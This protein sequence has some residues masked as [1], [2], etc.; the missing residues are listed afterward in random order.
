MSSILLNRGF[1]HR[2]AND[3]TSGKTQPLTEFLHYLKLVRYNQLSESKGNFFLLSLD[4]KTDEYIRE[5]LFAASHENSNPLNPKIAKIQIDESAKKVASEISANQ[6][7]FL[8]CFSKID[9]E[10][11]ILEK[12][13]EK[14]A[15]VASSEPERT[16]R[17]ESKLDEFFTEMVRFFSVLKPGFFR[18]L[19]LEREKVFKEIMESFSQ[20]HGSNFLNKVTN[21]K[22]FLRSYKF[23]AAQ[24][25]LEISS[26]ANKID[27]ITRD[28]LSQLGVTVQKLDLHPFDVPLKN[29]VGFSSVQYDEVRVALYHELKKEVQILKGFLDSFEGKKATGKETRQIQEATSMFREKIM[30]IL[31]KTEY[32]GISFF[33]D[34]IIKR[35]KETENIRTVDNLGDFIE[36]II[37][38]L[39]FLGTVPERTGSKKPRE[40]L[41]ILKDEFELRK[42]EFEDNNPGAT[43]DLS[44]ADFANYVSLKKEP[45]TIVGLLNRVA[46]EI[47]TSKTNSNAEGK[48]YEALS[49]FSQNFNNVLP[50]FLDNLE[51]MMATLKD[52]SDSFRFIAEMLI[53]ADAISGR[54]GDTEEVLKFSS[55]NPKDPALEFENSPF[56]R[57]IKAD[58]DVQK[59]VNN[60]LTTVAL[61]RAALFRS[62]I[63]SLIPRNYSEWKNPFVNLPRL[64]D[65]SLIRYKV[66]EF[67]PYSAIQKLNQLN[68]T[69][70]ES[71][72]VEFL[73]AEIDTTIPGEYIYR[74]GFPRSGK[75]SNNSAFFSENQNIFTF[76][77]TSLG[78]HGK[79]LITETISNEI[80]LHKRN[81]SAPDLFIVT[82][83]KFV[84]FLKSNKYFI[85]TD[86]K[87][88]RIN[89][90][91]KIISIG[92]TRYNRSANSIPPIEG[93]NLKKTL[94]ILLDHSYD[95]RHRRRG[96]TYCI[97]Y[98]NRECKN[99]VAFDNERV[100]RLTE[101]SDLDDYTREALLYVANVTK[102]NTQPIVKTFTR[103]E[104]SLHSKEFYLTVSVVKPDSIFYEPPRNLLPD[105]LARNVPFDVRVVSTNVLPYLPIIGLYHKQI[106]LSQKVE[107]ATAKV[108][109]RDPV[110]MKYFA[111]RNENNF[112]SRNVLDSVEVHD[113]KDPK[114]Q[115]MHN[116][117][118]VLVYSSPLQMAIDI[119]SADGKDDVLSIFN[120]ISRKNLHI[121]WKKY[122]IPLTPELRYNIVRYFNNPYLTS[123][124]EEE[125][126]QKFGSPKI[127]SDSS[128]YTRIMKAICATMYNKLCSHYFKKNGYIDFTHVMNQITYE[129][130]P[131]VRK[132]LESVRNMPVFSQFKLKTETNLIID[133]LN[134]E[135]SNISFPIGNLVNGSIVISLPSIKY[136]SDLIDFGDDNTRTIKT[137]SVANPG[138]TFVIDPDNLVIANFNPYSFRKMKR[139]QGIAKLIDGKYKMQINNQSEQSTYLTTIEP[140]AND[141]T[142]ERLKRLLDCNDRK[143]VENKE[144]ME[145][146]KASQTKKEITTL[147]LLL[148]HSFWFMKLDSNTKFRRNLQISGE[149]TEL[150]C[151]MLAFINKRKTLPTKIE[152]FENEEPLYVSSI[153]REEHKKIFFKRFFMLVTGAEITEESSMDLDRELQQF[154]IT[155]GLVKQK[156]PDRFNYLTDIGLHVTEKDSEIIVSDDFFESNEVIPKII[157]ESRPIKMNIA[158][159]TDR[160][161]NGD[162]PS[163]DMSLLSNIDIITG[164]NIVPGMIKLLKNEKITQSSVGFFLHEKLL[165]PPQR[166]EDRERLAFFFKS[167]NINTSNIHNKL[168]EREKQNRV[169]PA[170]R[171]GTIQFNN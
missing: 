116:T 170:L 67:P 102:V 127:A 162:V 74:V 106:T 92:L 40:L 159:Y 77:D 165:P 32:R 9:K 35:S 167:M 160:D 72:N 93:K 54:F 15:A 11:G 82:Q 156:A 62:K 14:G 150:F 123:L 138:I 142:L 126:S 57:N 18:S 63:D 108:P 95:Y 169:S 13:P 59:I 110:W 124:M 151:Q 132:T 33:G 120:K 137:L 1:L 149:D 112:S 29:W 16:C 85:E 140:I 19:G 28:L 96:K 125:E 101:D 56:F 164:K 153:A 161:I 81:A 25:I 65:K 171:S 36:G 168:I 46:A 87:K 105:D 99:F 80:T 17:L 60:E 130:F 117:G 45:S 51:N 155:E 39:S 128:S 118:A 43:A 5:N 121:S 111:N 66:P 113:A 64:D 97:T 68:E 139:I 131:F 48:T 122:K 20:Y 94:E 21:Y 47:K 136:Y 100:Y 90:K 84:S 24:M 133:E 61:E 146:K 141:V 49:K 38:L 27:E 98:E 8:E 42:K 52:V 4:D 58:S 119:V 143:I 30:K 157:F 2:A 10:L 114:K 34:L 163:L 88:N 26:I 134:R 23:F 70:V 83:F 12:K 76:V 31:G 158:N 41:D 109:A 73:K 91:S 7:K 147:D 71:E 145:A 22:S 79:I 115:L 3:F 154:N 86:I 75:F 6:M 78:S 104:D 144:E 44:N 37:P 89:E 107:N 148:N 55:E 69:I 53:H 152:E 129:Q 135:D 166:V 50:N 103:R